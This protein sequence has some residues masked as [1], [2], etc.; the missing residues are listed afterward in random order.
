MSRCVRRAFLCGWDRYSGRDHE[1]RR[2]WV[3]DRLEE[4]SKLFGVEVFSYAVMSNHLHVVVRI[5]PDWVSQWSDREVA[6]R[7]SRLFRGKAAIQEGKAYDEKKLTRLLQD[8]EKLL[9][10]RERLSDLSWFMRCTNEWL[11][12]RANKEDECTGRFW[13]GRF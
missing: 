7:W 4:L 6:E 1:H 3:R 11:A 2:G 13:E 5:R 8:P 10:C 12:R 9:Q